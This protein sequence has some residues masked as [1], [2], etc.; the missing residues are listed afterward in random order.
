MS[1]PSPNSAKSDFTGSDGKISFIVFVSSIV[2]FMVADFGFPD[3]DGGRI[4]I[5]VA[6]CITCVSS[7]TKRFSFLYQE[8]QSPMSTGEL[9]RTIHRKSM[10]TF[11]AAVVFE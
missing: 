9:S 3:E 5:F 10:F 6:S 11:F 7:G 4:P 1:T 8:L 2:V